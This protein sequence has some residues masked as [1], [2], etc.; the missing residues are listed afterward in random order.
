MDE[1]TFF[2]QATLLICSSLEVEVSLFRCLPFLRG[3][4]G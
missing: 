2:R 4:C 1:N 3:P